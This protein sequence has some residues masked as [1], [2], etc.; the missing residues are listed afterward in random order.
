[1]KK[2][3]LI[4]GVNGAG[5]STLYRTLDSLQQME[6]INTDE[7][8]R[9][10][11][12]WNNPADVLKAGKIAVAKI[13]DCFE[14]GITFNQETT[15]CG[16]VVVKNIELARKL[17]YEVELHYVGVDTVEIAKERIAYRVAH[18]GHGISD[19][20]VERRYKESFEQLNKLKSNCDLVI[21]YDN[22]NVFE[23]FAI[24]KNGNFWGEEKKFPLWFK[25]YIQ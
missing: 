22:T 10:F 1:M 4:A 19:S 2:Y 11:G 17:G 21:L 16:N 5:K 6:R 24:Y 3:I 25:K 9:S 12:D 18:G 8:I 7:I 20:D 23:R 14:K 15:L 13:K